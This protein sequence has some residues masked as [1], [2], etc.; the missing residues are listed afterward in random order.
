M[1][2]LIGFVLFIAVPFML[3]ARTRSY[4][5]ALVPVAL[6]VFAI[7]QYRT[8]EPTGDETDALPLVFMIGSGLGVLVCLAGTAF[9]RRFRP[10]AKSTR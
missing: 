7:A 3:G 9:G 5:S 10:S 4:W 8:Y 6:L 2:D 1:F